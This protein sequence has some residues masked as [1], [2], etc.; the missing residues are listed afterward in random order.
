MKGALGQ[1][2]CLDAHRREAYKEERPGRPSEGTKVQPTYLRAA[3]GAL[4][5]LPVYG[6]LTFLATLTQQPDPATDFRAW[7][8]YVTTGRFYVSH[9]GA[10]VL[11]LAV[12]TLGVLGLGLL[13]SLAGRAKAALTAVVMHV[14]GASIVFGL[15]GIAAFVQ[16]AMGAAFLD[17]EPAAH[18]WYDA[19]FNVPA[20]LVPALIGLLVFSLASVVMGWALRAHPRVPMWAAMTY[21]I[22]GPLIGVLGLVMGSLQT[23]GSALLTASAIVVAVRLGDALPSGGADPA[24]AV[25]GASAAPPASDV[26]G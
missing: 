16:P 20:T 2:P 15:F 5:L 10:S 3:R 19:V 12:G 8:E 13:S 1:G 17:G 24:V 11:G 26:R 6:V 22:S 21:G 4:W 18:G 25:R 7:S 14:L 9:L 23:V